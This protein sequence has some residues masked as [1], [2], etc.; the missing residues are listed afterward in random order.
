MKSK[1]FLWLAAG[2]L[3]IMTG[4]SACSLYR[5]DRC[6]VPEDQ[7]EL[8]RDVYVETGSLDLVEQRLIDSQWKRCK[9]NEVVYR[10]N[11]EFSVLPE[12][13]PQPA[14]AQPAEE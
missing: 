5:N 9:I 6:Y 7:Y 14:Q 2:A 3:A 1:S 4:P 13:L 8:A 11:K 12:E 10:L